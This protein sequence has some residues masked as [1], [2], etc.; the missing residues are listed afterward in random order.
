MPRFTKSKSKSKRRGNKPMDSEDQ[1]ADT[2]ENDQDVPSIEVND[3]EPGAGHGKRGKRKLKGV[4]GRDKNV[5][6]LGRG[7]RVLPRA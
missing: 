6:Q 5:V 3:D 2:P 1:E 4:T 7:P